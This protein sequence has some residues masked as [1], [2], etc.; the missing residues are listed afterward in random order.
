M[1]FN[2]VAERSSTRVAAPAGGR[3]SIDFSGGYQ[4][5]GPP[6]PKRVFQSA[7]AEFI[8]SSTPPNPSERRDDRDIFTKPSTRLHQPPGGS[9]S[10]SFGY[11]GGNA[12][13]PAPVG[14]TQGSERQLQYLSPPV[15]TIENPVDELD[16]LTRKH[17][18]N[19]SPVSVQD[20]R[21]DSVYGR[22]GYSNPPYGTRQNDPVT[23][24]RRSTR[25]AQAPGGASSISFG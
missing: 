8:G 16:L 25:V 15:S 3:S 13:S 5:D 4:Q 1:Y 11:D 12:H 20:T 23:G 14:R 24:A 18:P 19:F 21:S 2:N 9:S 10:I 6:R 22:G 17:T 7:A